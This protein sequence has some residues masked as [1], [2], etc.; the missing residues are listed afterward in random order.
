[1]NMPGF[2]AEASLRRTNTIARRL[3]GPMHRVEGSVIPQRIKLQE[4]T[5]DCDAATD[6]CICK[7]EHGA[8]R[9]IHAVL[10]EL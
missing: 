1:M 6:I 8:I 3:P 10:G 7:S 5:C 9:A 4:W 2:T